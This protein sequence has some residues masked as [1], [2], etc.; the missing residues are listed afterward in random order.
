MTVRLATDRQIT[1][2]MTLVGQVNKVIMAIDPENGP[3]C[4]LANEQGWQERVERTTITMREASEAIDDLKAR[5]ASLRAERPA[6][7]RPTDG[8]VPVGFY[9]RDGV[10]YRVVKSRSSS[11]HYAKRLDPTTGR[12]EYAAG[13]IRTLTESDELSPEAAANLGHQYGI[14]VCC[15]ADLTDPESIER[16]IGPV[17]Y[18]N[19]VGRKSA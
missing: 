17:C 13:V 1:Y 4:A 16:G 11:N 10:V 19:L 5:L 18:R 9:L 2:I 12:F 15:G 14:C 3:E 8:P 7:E 6:P